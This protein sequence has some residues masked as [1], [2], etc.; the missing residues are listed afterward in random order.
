MPVR[1]DVPCI[2]KGWFSMSCKGIPQPLVL[3]KD[4][5]MWW[6]KSI[7]FALCCSGKQPWSLFLSLG[8]RASFRDQW[9]CFSSSLQCSNISLHPSHPC[10][11]L[12]FLGNTWVTAGSAAL[13][14]VRQ[15][16]GRG[17]AGALHGS[18]VSPGP[19]WAL[20]GACNCPDTCGQR[21]RQGKH[22]GLKWWLCTSH[23]SQAFQLPAAAGHWQCRQ[24]IFSS[25]STCRGQ[26]Q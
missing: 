7:L 11:L 20:G 25:D 10:S 22:A 12:P 13:P 21:R 1:K 4:E 6:N 14:A 3:F 8:T 9:L 18:E 16:R 2:N 19:C 24:D 26:W 5:Y 15:N 23:S 17:A